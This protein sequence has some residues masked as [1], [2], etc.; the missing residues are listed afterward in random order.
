MTLPGFLVIGEAKCG[1]TTLWSMLRAHPGIWFP[2]EKELHFFGSY[3]SFGPCGRAWSDPLDRYAREFAGVGPG[4]IGAEATPNYLSDPGAADRIASS[5]PGVRA[6]AILRDPVHRA[7][8]H[9]WHQVRRG[10]E[11]KSFER[12]LAL[13]DRRLASGDPDDY[14][15]YSYAT[16]GRY[17]EGL[18]RFAEALGKDRVCVV[19]LEELRREP[20]SV[21]GRVLGHLGLEPVDSIDAVPRANRADYP[22]WAAADR[23]KRRVVGLGDRLGPA[24]GVPMRVVGRATRRWRVYQGTPRMDEGTRGDLERRFAEPD[25]SLRAWLGR[26]LPWRDEVPGGAPGNGEGG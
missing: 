7:W 3:T 2:E 16:R 24:V 23:L 20:A 10:V 8:S 6:V 14:E 18:S 17:V 19:F 1:T 25:R 26:A 22:R 5:L 4:Q 13:E 9:Y 12:A 11:G 15:R 21:I